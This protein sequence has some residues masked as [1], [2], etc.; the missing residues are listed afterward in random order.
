MSFIAGAVDVDTVR[1]RLS[2]V[3]RVFHSEAD[4]QHAFAWVLH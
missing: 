3:R 2:S 4:F 1:A